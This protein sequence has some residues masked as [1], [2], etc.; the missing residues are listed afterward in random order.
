MPKRKQSIEVE[1]LDSDGEDIQQYV[2]V[3]DQQKFIKN[4]KKYEEKKNKHGVIYI[5]R[6]PPFMRPVKVRSLMEQY[7]TVTNIYL[8]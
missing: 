1:G 5:S 2:D 3:A 6:V 8:S 7:G 4:A